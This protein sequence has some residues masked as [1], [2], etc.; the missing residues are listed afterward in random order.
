MD[1]VLAYYCISRHVFVLIKKKRN[2][3]T[4]TKSNQKKKKPLTYRKFNSEFLA[5]IYLSSCRHYFNTP[6]MGIIT[7]STEHF[8]QPILNFLIFS[9]RNHH[10]YIITPNQVIKKPR[11]KNAIKLRG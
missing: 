9:F 11:V 5:G 3:P 2:T 7:D 6:V 10:I 4:N 8:L 1:A